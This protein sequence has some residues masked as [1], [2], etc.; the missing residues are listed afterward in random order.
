[1]KIFTF[2]AAICLLGMTSCTK[3]LCP[4]YSGTESVK[5][6]ILAKEVIAPTGTAQI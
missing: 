4:A 2:L 1:M 6:N 3:K 5:Q